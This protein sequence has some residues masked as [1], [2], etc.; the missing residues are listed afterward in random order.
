M[1]METNYY[2]VLN[3]EILGQNLGRNIYTCYNAS[4]Y[5][6]QFYITFN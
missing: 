5:N 6:I 3:L 4:V 2:R 1:K